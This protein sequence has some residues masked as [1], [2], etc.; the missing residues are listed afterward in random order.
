MYQKRGKSMTPNAT[1]APMKSTMR[2]SMRLVTS[3]GTAAV[4]PYSTARLPPPPPMLPLLMPPLL[5]PL[6][7]LLLP[8]G[9]A[10]DDDGA[11]PAC[12]AAWAAS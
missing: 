5:M 11:S 6:P 2:P 4:L 10:A 3:S 1:G 7:L 9:G 8:A 12:P